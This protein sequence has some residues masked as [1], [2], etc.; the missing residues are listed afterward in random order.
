MGGGG[1]IYAERGI[2]GFGREEIL[3][4]EGEIGEGR[5]REG[6]CLGGS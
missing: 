6:E 2:R 5:E 1:Y 3:E 4:R